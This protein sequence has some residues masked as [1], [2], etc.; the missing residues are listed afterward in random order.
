MKARVPPPYRLAEL[1]ERVIASLGAW[2]MSTVVPSSSLSLEV[3]MIRS[4]ARGSITSVLSLCQRGLLAR[5]G[6]ARC[7]ARAG[8]RRSG[9]GPRP[10]GLDEVLLLHVLHRQPAEGDAP[11]EGDETVQQGGRDRDG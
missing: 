9:P 7:E 3:W 8:R 1:R 6:G 10:V 2:T 5:R 4:I 11:V